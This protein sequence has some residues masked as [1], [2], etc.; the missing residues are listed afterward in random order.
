MIKSKRILGEKMQKNKLFIKYEEVLNRSDLLED[1]VHQ[2]L[3]WIG[4]HDQHLI[5]DFFVDKF[6]H[7]NANQFKQFI[8]NNKLV[9]LE[10]LENPL[11]KEICLLVKL[12]ISETKV[13]AFQYI[14]THIDFFPFIKAHSSILTLQDKE[15]FIKKIKHKYAGT[16]S[17]ESLEE[18]THL[19]ESRLYGL[20]T[21]ENAFSCFDLNDTILFDLKKS[22]E[23]KLKEKEKEVFF[24]KLKKTFDSPTLNMETVDDFIQSHALSI[25]EFLGVRA[26][27]DNLF[28]YLNFSEEKIKFINEEQQNKLNSITQKLVDEKE[29]IALEKEK[30]RQLR[31][32]KKTL[33][34]ASEVPSYLGIKPSQFKKWIEDGRIPIADTV[35]FKKRGK[36]MSATKHDPAQLTNITPEVINRWIEE[37]NKNK[38]KKTRV[39]SQASKDKAKWTRHWTRQKKQL[40][41][42]G[43]Y[44]EGDTIAQ[45][46]AIVFKLEGD[47]FKHHLLFK[48]PLTEAVKEKENGLIEFA[49]S[50]FEIYTIESLSLK[51]KEQIQMLSLQYLGKI[52]DIQ[53]KIFVHESLLLFIHQEVFLNQLFDSSLE[54]HFKMLQKELEVLR[55][56]K[57]VR[58]VLNL[59]DYAN[60]Y[61][62]A[63]GLNREVKLIVGPTNSGK[64]FEALETLKN[65][66]S[67]VYLAPLRLLAMEVF[68]KLNNAGIP[69]NLHTGEE[70]IDMPG[71]KHTASTIEM[72]DSKN[73]VDVAVIDEF[74]M[75]KDSSRGWAWTAA[76]TGVAAKQVFAVGSKEAL[77]MTVQLFKYLKEDYSIVELERKTPLILLK[78]PVTVYDVKKHDIVVAFTRKDVLNIA[79]QLRKRGLNVSAIYGSLSPEVRRKQS[80]LFLDGT[81]DV[82]VA[83][84]AIG[85]GL[86]LPAARVIFSTTTKFDGKEKRKLLPTEIKQIAGRAGRFGLFE[87]GEYSAFSRYD[88]NYLKEIAH[89]KLNETFEKMQI[90]PSLKHVLDLQKHLQL[91]DNKIHSLIYYFSQEFGIQNPLF[92]NA[93]LDS[94]LELA[95]IVDQVAPELS[96]QDKYTCICAPVSINKE[97]DVNYYKK[98]ILAIKDNV[99]MELFALPEWINDE[100]SQNLE[101]AENLT[102]NLSIYSWLSFRFKDIFVERDVVPIYRNKLSQYIASRLVKEKSSFYEW[103]K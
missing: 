81:H 17:Y 38:I 49:H 79:A 45:R 68:D 102:K 22:H 86:N 94:M 80:Q 100:I 78:D 76:L 27:K 53:E 74:Q 57:S 88:L 64:T 9:S 63:R 21:I 18:I 42:Q 20:T 25:Y 56:Q 41:N 72:M 84:D 23:E 30:E 28:K 96:M 73:I 11:A 66:N 12:I 15:H 8:N 70:H 36:Q 3:N 55:S 87:K 65:A 6:E 69:C 10:T 26:N 95:I 93:S 89:E 62:I 16:L 99:E 92:K 19:K 97:E 4:H 14:N 103:W 1:I 44:F 85:M 39:V 31:V 98:T 52:N 67:G 48:L 90:A 7:F 82:V 29:A 40:I 71:A 60:N 5:N 13:S 34:H 77:E 58:E 24:H 101:Q 50:A 83:T 2:L 37:D 46:Y 51:L 61:P 35:F 54:N 47:I 59:D 43:F 75:L 91:N 32:W 33:I